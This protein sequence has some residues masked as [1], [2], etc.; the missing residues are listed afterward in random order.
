MIYR[1]DTLTTLPTLDHASVQTIVTSPPYYGLRDYGLPPSQWSAIEYAPMPGLPPVIVEAQ[2]ACLGLEET[3]FAYVAHLVHLFRLLRDIL[4]DD[5]TVWLNLGDTYANPSK[6]GGASGKKNA[7]SAAGNYPRSRRGRQGYTA[8][9]AAEVADVEHRRPQQG[10]KDKDLYGIPWRVA[11]A[12][13]ADGWYLRSDVIWQKPNGMPESVDD[14]PTKA[15]EYVFLLAKNEHYYYDADA[16]AEPAR[17]WPG[18][19]GTFKRE[20]SKRSDAIVPG[21]TRGTHR[22][23]R[24]DSAQDGT[25]NARSVWSIPTKA[26]NEAH[27]APMPEAL[28]ERCIRAGSRPGDTVLDPFAGTGTTLRVAERLQRVGVGIELNEHYHDII[29]RRTNGVQLEAFV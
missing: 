9:S 1:G 17:I 21:Q 4:C 12:L 27:Y 18:P 5:G 11:F 23:D 28:A 19:A 14:R 2:A 3:P 24:T 15:H 7:T 16:I 6:W 29:E 13:Q 26:L 25:R 8:H 20:K 10:M 22:A